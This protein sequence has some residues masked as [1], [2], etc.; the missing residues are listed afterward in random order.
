[1]HNILKGQ[2]PYHFMKIGLIKN[3][4]NVIK[5]IEKFNYCY[6]FLIAFREKTDFPISILKN[7]I[8]TFL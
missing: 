1:M 3:L 4:L 5:F 7:C 2:N 8:K 6:Q